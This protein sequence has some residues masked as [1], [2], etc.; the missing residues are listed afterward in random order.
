MLWRR[1]CLSNTADLKITRNDAGTI[2]QSL[3]ATCPQW[4]VFEPPHKGLDDAMA[5]RGLFAQSSLHKTFFVIKYIQIIDF[6]E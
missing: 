5:V 1:G 4:F 6:S 3:R 2:P